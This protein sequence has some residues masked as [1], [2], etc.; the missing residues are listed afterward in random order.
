MKIELTLNGKRTA[1]DVPP[2]MRLLDALRGPL[3][4]TGTKEGCGEGECGTCAVLLDGE[5]VNACL[6]AIGQCEGREVV[7]DLG[8]LPNNEIVYIADVDIEA[9]ERHDFELRALKTPLDN[10]LWSKVFAGAENVRGNALTVTPHG[11]IVVVGTETN[12]NSS[13][14]VLAAHHP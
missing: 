8:R 14:L 5:P 9:E 2:M 6:V 4:L 10:P 7:T 13:T 3:G 11:I 1:V 12:A